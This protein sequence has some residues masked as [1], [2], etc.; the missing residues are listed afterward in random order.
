MV[1]ADALAVVA[2]DQSEVRVGE[3]LQAIVL[4]D[5]RHVENCPW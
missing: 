1:H 2:E 3:E 4:D 5:H